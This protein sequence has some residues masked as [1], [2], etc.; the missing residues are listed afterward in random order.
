MEKQ[1]ILKS[2]KEL[3]EKFAKKKFKQSIDLLINLKDMDIKKA[4]N[5]IDLFLQLPHPSEKK[6]KLGAFV[7]QQLGVQANKLFDI[8]VLKEDFAKWNN[9]K[10]QKKLASSYDLFVSQIEVMSLVATNFGKVFGARGKMPNPKAGCVVSGTANL[11]PLVN[12]LKNTIR[13]KTKNEA[14]IKISIGAEDTPD[15]KLVDNVLFIYSNLLLKLPQEKQNIKYVALKYTM[16]PLIKIK[17]ES[18]AADKKAKRIKN[19]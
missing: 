9:K 6:L 5:N 8:V 11:E 18:K 14:S 17:E 15:D 13:I 16:S 3:K 10:D 7:D 2:I 12:K 19:A 4:E 1:D